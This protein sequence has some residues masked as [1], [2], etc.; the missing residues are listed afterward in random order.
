MNASSTKLSDIG[1]DPLDPHPLKDTAFLRAVVNSPNI[2]VGDYSYYNDPKGPEN[3]VKHCVKYHFDFIGDKLIIGKFCAIAADVQFIMNGANHA[4]GGFSTFPF[5]VFANGWKSGF[6]PSTI[7]DGLRGDTMIGSD[8]WIGT[9]ATIMPGVTIGHGAI[10]GAKAVV[11]KDVPPYTIVAGNPAAV[12]RQ[13][14]D[15]KTTQALLDLAWWDWPIEN[16]N[17]AINAIRGADLG[18][19][20]GFRPR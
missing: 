4:M 12:I 14:F 20:K 8:V 16:I 18:V 1:P 19:L 3:F 5:N 15:E 10:I 7:T 6:E 2:E 13:R 17:K 9:G 11:G